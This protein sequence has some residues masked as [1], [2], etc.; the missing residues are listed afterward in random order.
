MKISLD[1]IKDYLEMPD[2]FD[3]K[4]LAYDL[5]MATVEV[6]AMTFLAEKFSLMVVGVINEIIPH[7][8]ADKLRIC[9]TEIGL[10]DVRE[11]VC[12]G[13]NLAVG[14]KV[15]VAK[16]G[17]YVRW[18]GEGELVEIKNAK[19]RGI[20]SF[21]MICASSEIGLFDLFP[22][23]EEATI[24]D[25]SEFTEAYAGTPLADALGLND[26][27]LEIDNKSLTNRPDLW[28]HY[29]IAREISALFDLPMRKGSFATLNKLANAELANK[30]FTVKISDS[31]RCRRYIGVEMEGLSVKPAPFKIKSRIWRVGMNPINAIVDITNYVMLAT[32]QPTH[33]F[34]AD[35]ISGMINVRRAFEDEKLLLLNEKELSLNPS[36]LVIADDEG[37]V[38]L[39]GVMGGSKDSIIANT[40]RVILE[41]ANFEAISVRH[42]AARHETRT[43]SAARFEK[44]IDPERCD[45]ALEIALELFGEIY[46]GLNIT[47]YCDNFPTKLASPEINVSL[48]WLSRRLG[49]TLPNNEIEK[50]LLKL[51]FSVEIKNDNLLITPPPW[52]S[53]GDISIPNDIM[54]E[55]ARMHGFENFTQ[56]PMITS[57]NEAINQPQIDIER[58]IKEYLSFRCGMNEI[59]TYPWMNDDFADQFI[60]ENDGRVLTLSTPPS[61]EESKLR[62]T[63]L[64]N[65]CRAVSGNLR[66]FDEFAI[67]E[68]AYVLLADRFAVLNDE[69]E[70]LP[71]QR[72]SIAGAMVAGRDKTNDSFRKVKGFIDKMP[73]YTH[74]EAFSFFKANK[75]DWADDIVWLNILQGEKKVGNLALLS[76]A[77]TLACGIKNAAVMIFELDID[78]LLTLD[79]RTNKFTHLPYYP[80][81]D[82]DFSVLVD[83]NVKWQEI[84]DAVTKKMGADSFIRGVSFVDEYHG[85][86]IPA[87]KKSVTLRL[88]VGAK[89]KTLKQEEIESSV[90]A[91]T[92]RLNKVVGAELR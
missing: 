79:S 25:L 53:T 61:P 13:I 37:A 86:Q 48:E 9:R 30:D 40:N 63:L 19:L 68:G 51:G 16:P 15:A 7:P 10:G 64:P 5:T 62:S 52:R 11:I 27:I 42:T 6:E 17:A 72:R 34:D 14:M 18:H 8:N 90:K 26:I 66:Y 78:A 39:A 65:L 55:V 92:K 88:V 69:R 85:K 91:V 1:W 89:D 23:E 38:A 31:K 74:L 45:Q 28:G 76:T 70:K 56:S 82:Y 35:N 22:Y 46:E 54:E 73:R 2:D 59:F 41:I 80:L 47:G 20:E 33:A 83:R 21:G 32:G 71:S 36:D 67:Y 3:M 60:S 81:T 77:K 29:G 87:D 57:F 49:K 44:A 84:E 4:K 58:K 24:M 43:E 12:G 50:M 75:P